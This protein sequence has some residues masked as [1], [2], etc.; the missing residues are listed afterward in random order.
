MSLAVPIYTMLYMA[1]TLMNR[2][3][4]IVKI[5]NKYTFIIRIFVTNFTFGRKYASYAIV[6]QLVVS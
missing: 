6:L 1:I 3:V 2:G 4:I 5:F